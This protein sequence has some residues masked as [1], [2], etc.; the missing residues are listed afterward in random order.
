V[1]SFIMV[2][3]SCTVDEFDNSTVISTEADDPEIVIINDMVNKSRPA[4]G[5]AGQEIGCIIVKYPFQVVT[6]DSIVHD[7]NSNFDFQQ[8]EQQSTIFIVDF[9]YPLNILDNIGVSHTVQSLWELASYF[10]GCY[11]DSLSVNN[12]E[13]PAFLI[14]ENSSCYTIKYPISVKDNT[15][16]IYS[17]ASDTDFIALLSQK[18]LLFVFPFSL[19][20]MFQ[21]EKTITSP[22]DLEQALFDCNTN[23]I[24]DTMFNYEYLACYKLIYPVSI[25]VINSVDPLIVNSPDMMSQIFYQGKFVDFVFPINLE[26]EDGKILVIPNATALENAINN[27]Y[28]FGDLI[29]LLTGTELFSNTPC[30]NIVFPIQAKSPQGNVNTY[31]NLSQMQ[32]ILADSMS[33]QYQ[34]VYPLDVVLKKNSNQ[35]TLNDVFDVI[36]LLTDC[37]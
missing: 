15:N 24:V 34:I 28:I 3:A 13:F 11:P 26:D 21:V 18:D 17:L 33:T 22:A 27:C 36:E 14:D 4:I 25:H 19:L 20:D 16:K 1:F 7:V 12:Q 32:P 2:F 35:R 5:N 23:I 30:Y 6:S 37:N 8:L 10:A 31:Q 29:L 9:K